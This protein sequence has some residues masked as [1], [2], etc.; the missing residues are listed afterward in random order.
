M[1]LRYCI[2]F[3]FLIAAAEASP[4]PLLL[5]GI[6]GGGGNV[7]GTVP[8]QYPANPEIVKNLMLGVSPN[9]VPL[10]RKK[11]V[12]VNDGSAS[13]EELKIFSPLFNKNAEGDDIFNV[14]NKTEIEIPVEHACFDS[15][16]DPVDGS[17]IVAQ[18]RD[19]ICVSAFSISRK[20]RLDEVPDQSLALILHEF[21]EKF[22]YV[23]SQAIT[24]QKLILKELQE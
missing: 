21:S 20:L 4:S 17:I 7:I 15:A 23:E 13:S 12:S 19:A 10:L 18:D 9:L 6:S 5:G 24:L 11:K 1:K 16:M 3:F 8:P 2:L 14:I 22:G